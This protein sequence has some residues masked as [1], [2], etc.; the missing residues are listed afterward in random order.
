[1]HCNLS[2]PDTTPVFF[3]FNYKKNDLSYGIKIWTEISSRFVT[4]YAFDRQTDG[5]TNRQ[6]SHR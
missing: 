6:N 4:I 3:R 5:Q 2:L 1:M